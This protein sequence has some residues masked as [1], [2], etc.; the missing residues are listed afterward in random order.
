MTD[1][2]QPISLDSL[3]V[4]ERAVD[5]PYPGIEGVTFKLCFLSRNKTLELR[6][7]SSTKLWNPKRQMNEEQ[8]DEDKFVA[9]FAK[10]V[11]RGW[12]GLKLKHLEEL[13]LVDLSA[14]DPD[15]D[16]PYTE[17]NA[18]TLIR[19]SEEIDTWVAAVCGELENFTLNK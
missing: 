8:L 7:Q 13:L 9:K 6:K 12:S 17:E 14:Q 18:L 5:V 3:L 4:S 15:A 2:Q 10:F 16:F 19:N 1:N 11:I